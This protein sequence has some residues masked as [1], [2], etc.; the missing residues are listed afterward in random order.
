MSSS[1]L[2][3][4]PSCSCVQSACTL[5]CLN[6]YFLVYFGSWS[7]FVYF[8]MIA[9]VPLPFSSCFV[10]ASVHLMP[11]LILLLFVLPEQAYETWCFLCIFLNQVSVKCLTFIQHSCLLCLPWW[12]MTLFMVLLNV[13]HH[14]ESFCACVV[15]IL[16]M[17]FFIYQRWCEGSGQRREIWG[18]SAG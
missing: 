13:F 6:C 16:H 3:L 9:F 7:S 14:L 15:A 2:F 17:L 10:S 4:F 12:N 11:V 8:P 18:K 5:I 1:W